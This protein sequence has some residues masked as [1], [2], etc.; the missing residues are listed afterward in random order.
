[1]IPTLELVQFPGGGG[2]DLDFSGEKQLAN[3]PQKPWAEN[4]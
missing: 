2:E 1:M 4:S 3:L